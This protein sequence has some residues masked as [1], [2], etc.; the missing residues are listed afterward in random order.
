M[1]R[2]LKQW[3]GR[4]FGLMLLGAAS[5][6]AC[7]GG[8]PDAV[9]VAGAVPAQ[10]G[11]VPDVSTPTIPGLQMQSLSVDQ[12]L[13]LMSGHAAS[14]LALYRA[15]AANE[16]AHHLM[17]LGAGAKA[18]E[19]AG[20]DALGFKPELFN[21][22]STELEAGKQAV[23]IEPL[24]VEA[25][26]N[27][28]EMR[29]AAGGNPKALVEFLM[30]NLA[31][32]Y[33]SGVDNS[34]IVNLGDYQDAY[35]YALVARDIAAAQDP[36]MFGALRLEL[37]LLVLMWPGKG[38]LSTSLPPPEFQMAEQLARVKLALASLP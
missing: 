32:E 25:E 23:E 13:A 1:D 21:Q 33:D 19:V 15:G 3:K 7:G 6:A 4:G 27:L 22:I 38:P 29:R 24:L 34:V 5:L 36:A 28:A 16:A 26:T 31:T 17:H 9:E 14:G 2:V 11:H 12:R 20:F 30:K 18:D 10:S 8:T 35:G 37:D